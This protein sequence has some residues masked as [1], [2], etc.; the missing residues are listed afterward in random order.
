MVSEK[1]E[2]NSIPPE[3]FQALSDHYKLKL[4]SDVSINT[5]FR[6]YK[7]YADFTVG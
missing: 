4:F 7:Q 2:C 3:L 1:Y 6:F 5:A